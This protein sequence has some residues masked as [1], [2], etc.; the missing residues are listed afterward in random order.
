MTMTTLAL[1]N[2]PLAD[3]EHARAG[4][5]VPMMLGMALFWGAIILSR[6]Q[7]L[8]PLL[9]PRGRDTS[10]ESRDVLVG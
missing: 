7:A 5:M 2:L 1:T 10:I 8:R 4:W 9:R 3:T 6:N